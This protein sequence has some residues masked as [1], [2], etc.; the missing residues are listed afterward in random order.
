MRIL[1]LK[2]NATRHYEYPK[3]STILVTMKWS[4]VLNNVSVSLEGNTE[5]RGGY[6]YMHPSLP[7]VSVPVTHFTL[8]PVLIWPSPIVRG[9]ILPQEV[10]L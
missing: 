8:G 7:Q 2:E 9:R 10:K 4:S 5:E 6:I 1:Y 3:T